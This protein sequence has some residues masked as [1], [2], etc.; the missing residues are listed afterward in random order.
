MPTRNKPK[1]PK[2]VHSNEISID[3]QSDSFTFTQKELRQSQDEPKPKIKPISNFPLSKAV[4][5]SQIKYQEN[6]SPVRISVFSINSNNSSHINEFTPKEDE[7]L[8]NHKENYLDMDLTTIE[9]DQNQN[10]PQEKKNL[11]EIIKNKIL[12]INNLNLCSDFTNYLDLDKFCEFTEVYMKI[13]VFKHSLVP[14][15]IPPF[16]NVTK[17]SFD[18]LETKKK[19][20][21]SVTEKNPMNK[22]N[23]G[24]HFIVGLL[25][26]IG[27]LILLFLII[28]LVKS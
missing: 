10:L 1:P 16:R 12:K 4:T 7:T 18:H 23:K 8:D 22:T 24:Y 17:N 20:Q 27:V 25:M 3:R 11:A 9:I 5:Q 14:I 2:S 13:K 28:L 6:N 15:Q 21:T 26:I 19:R